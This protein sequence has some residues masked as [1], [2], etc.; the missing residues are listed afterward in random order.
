MAALQRADETLCADRRP[1]YEQVQLPR[2]GSAQAAPVPS[3]SP[4]TH[5]PSARVQPCTLPSC[6]YTPHLWYTLDHD[7]LSCTRP[8]PPE[9][10]QKRSAPVRSRQ[11][12]L[13]GCLG[14]AGS[15]PAPVRAGG[16]Q[17]SRDGHASRGRRNAWRVR[18]AGTRNHRKLASLR[19]RSA[20]LGDSAGPSAPINYC[21][22]LGAC[23][24]G[25]T[26][27]SPPAPMGGG[28]TPVGRGESDSPQGT[29]DR[30]G[31]G[32]RRRHARWHKRAYT[33]EF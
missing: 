16:D 26:G 22:I 19:C 14:R 10:S 5:H 4:R 33:N 18:H 17:G 31:E 1:R 20:Q 15:N 13:A 29:R 2:A 21:C 27:H 28:T 7:G 9:S 30:E 3:E 25:R 8:R 24:S 32:Q 6:G 23:P 12:A 11:P